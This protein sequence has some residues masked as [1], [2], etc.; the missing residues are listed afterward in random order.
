MSGTASGLSYKL[1]PVTFAAGAPASGTVSLLNLHII[2][3]D[4]PA[5]WTA[6]TIT[7]LTSIDGITF[8]TTADVTGAEITITAAAST[9]IVVPPLSAPSA[10]FVKLQ[11]GSS[12]ATVNQVS[13]T[14][15]T[16]QCREYA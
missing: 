16:L 1:L 12:A 14:T 7:F 3:I 13:A 15:L 9:H 10:K 2:G 8:K 11:S 4:M 6:A 5:T